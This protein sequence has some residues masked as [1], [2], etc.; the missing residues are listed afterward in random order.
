MSQEQT[1]EYDTKQALLQETDIENAS[2]NID[3][4]KY[5]DNILT[6]QKL[7]LLRVQVKLEHERDIWTACGTTC[8]GSLI[9]Y[10]CQMLA[11][12]AVMSFSFVSIVK[13]WGQDNSVYFSLISGVVGYVLPSP[14]L[15]R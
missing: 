14:Q 6:T 13:N 10:T 12:A 1:T 8:S 7:G 5:G 4:P 15:A 3:T 9:K 11:C 2:V